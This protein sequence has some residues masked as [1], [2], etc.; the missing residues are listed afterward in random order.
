MTSELILTNGVVVTPQAVFHG[1]V[2]VV[3]RTIAAVDPAKS[4]ATSAVDLE[5]D[6]LIPGIVDVHTDNLER[7]LEPR[8]GVQ[9]PNLAA[10]LMH[11]RQVAAAGV[12]TVFDSLCVGDYDDGKAGRRDALVPSLK[13]TEEAQAAGLLKAEHLLHLRC[14]VSADGVVEAFTDFVDDPNVRLVSVM[15]HTPGQRQWANL[16]KWRQFNTRRNVSEAQL[17][18]ILERRRERQHRL[19]PGARRAIVSICR[20]RGLKLA[21]H[22]DTTAEHVAEAITDGIDISEFPTTVEAARLARAAGIHIVMG[23][24]N[25][26]LGGSHSG[27]VSARHLAGLGLVDGLASDYVPQ[28]LIQACFL[29]H[30]VVGLDV[31]Q[32]VDAVTRKP[33]AMVG[34]DDRGEIAPGKRAD[35]IRVRSYLHMPVVRSVWREGTLVA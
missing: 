4:H 2:H 21:S 9:W 12:T 28:S 31:C 33:A 20:H 11:D 25:V 3:G 22:D 14:E 30:E 10:L 27:N 32:A 13:A 24:P 7:H 15:D 18:E 17:M 29:F 19:A 6:Y 1:T 8:P 5:G 34:L 16:D 23:A 26:V 35:L